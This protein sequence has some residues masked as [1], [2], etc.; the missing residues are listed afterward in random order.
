MSMRPLIGVTA[1]EFEGGP[2]PR[3]GTFRPYLEAILDAGGVPVV[4]PL[5]AEG[6]D[7]VDDLLRRIDGLVLTGG[8][9]I[10]PARYGAAPHEKLGK[11][12]PM[13]DAVELALFHGAREQQIPILG[14]CRGLQLVNVG[15]GGSLYQDLPSECPGAALHARGETGWSDP[16]HTVAVVPD[17]LLHRTVGVGAFSIN[18]LHHQAVREL[19]RELRISGRCGADGSVEAVEG[20]SGGWLLAVQWHPE[21]LWSEEGGEP[22]RAIFR[23]FVEAAKGRGAG[24]ATGASPL[25]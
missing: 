8:E 24:T 17:S 25:L 4:L 13:R 19:G 15:C 12:A 10:S 2:L 20:T 18:S 3:L 21:V 5:S 7:W 23:R 9:D 1:R 11:I 22:H 16:V 6:S 14:I